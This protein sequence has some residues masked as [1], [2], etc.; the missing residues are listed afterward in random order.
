MTTDRLRL[1]YERVARL[2]KKKW[3]FVTIID[4]DEG[5]GKSTLA[6]KVATYTDPEF[7][8]MEGVKFDVEDLV[9]A[10][11]ASS[12]GKSLILDEGS[13][14]AWSIEAMSKENRAFKKV[15]QIARAKR[16]HVI[17][18]M[19]TIWDVD[20]FF[21]G[22]RARVWIHVNKRGEAIVHARQK[23]PYSKGEAWWEPVMIHN[24]GPLPPEVEAPYEELKMAYIKGGVAE[25]HQ[26]V[27]DKSND[28][29]N[30]SKARE[31]YLSNV[32]TDMLREPDRYVTASGRL[33]KGRVLGRWTDLTQ[34]EYSILSARAAESRDMSIPAG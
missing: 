6:V 7:H 14:G 16:V 24:Y 28:K 1:E 21:R 30:E 17:I 3:D 34:R 19:P 22:R 32:L 4:G 5:S 15:S 29:K 18:C 31:E 25:Q 12:P 8:V 9:A 33:K 2:L 10:I 20:K 26:L 11:G 23:N 13:E 27:R